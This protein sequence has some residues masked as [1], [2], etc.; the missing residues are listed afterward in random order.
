[1][2]STRFTVTRMAAVI[3]VALQAMTCWA[4]DVPRPMAD[5]L[6]IRVADYSPHQVYE[7]RVKRG[8]STRIILSPGEVIQTATPGL[9]S[10]CA[11]EGDE[12]CIHAPQGATQIVIRPRDGADKT[13]LEVQTSQRDYS[14]ELK[15]LPDAPPEKESA[16]NVPFF[17]VSFEYPAPPTPVRPVPIGVALPSASMPSSDAAADPISVEMRLAEAAPL[18]QNHQYTMQVL[19]G[20]EYAA[21]SAVFDD[22]RFTYFE[23]KGA[24][25]IPAVFAHGID[26]EP[27]RVNFSFD[28]R[29]QLLVVHRLA[30]R[31]TARLG[32]AV[33]GIFNEAFDPAGVSTPS[34]TV[35]SEVIR[36]NKETRP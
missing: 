21:P 14:F 31:F 19:P 9:S 36:E 32:K 29:R 34:G 33:V 25:E 12:W 13:N 28:S 16:H 35:V 23:Y 4:L 11:Q 17:R 2:K 24:R 15:V 22:G 30:Q 18:P 8:V 26:G 1:M 5:D 27:T 7:I 20:G 6:R 10:R 3:A